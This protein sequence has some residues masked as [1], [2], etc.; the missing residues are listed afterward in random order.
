MFTNKRDSA[1]MESKM[2]EKQEVE[3]G[4]SS[5]NKKFNLRKMKRDVLE[6]LLPNQAEFVS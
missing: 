5:I 6:A 2:L 3:K 4:K 1:L